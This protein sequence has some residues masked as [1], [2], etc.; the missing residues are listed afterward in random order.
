[1]MREDLVNYSYSFNSQQLADHYS[2]GG[3]AGAAK[4]AAKGKQKGLP[5]GNG[6]QAK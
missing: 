4:G 3:G 2:P 5:A 1:M 6:K